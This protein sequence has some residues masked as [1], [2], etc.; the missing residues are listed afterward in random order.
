[1]CVG[2]PRSRPGDGPSHKAEAILKNYTGLLPGLYGLYTMLGLKRDM[3]DG[4]NLVLH[5]ALKDGSFGP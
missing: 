5:L 2:T 1:M 4:P 3:A